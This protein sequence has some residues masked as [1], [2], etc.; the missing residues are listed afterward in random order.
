M[1]TEINNGD[2]GLAVRQSINN[3]F[4]ELY[5]MIPSAKANTLFVDSNGDD[6]TAEVGSLS[7]PWATV[8]GA[9]TYLADNNLQGYTII[10]FPGYYTESPW[11]FMSDNTTTVAPYNNNNNTTIKLLGDVHILSTGNLI[12]LNNANG[13]A[14]N[15]SIIGEN[16]KNTSIQSDTGTN[17]N[18]I[19]H[20]TSPSNSV[21]INLNIS[22]IKFI[23][24]YDSYDGNMGDGLNYYNISY[25]GYVTGKF[26]ANN[27]S[28]RN[29]IRNNWNKVYGASLAIWDATINM[30]NTYWQAGSD[31][32][33]SNWYFGLEDNFSTTVNINIENSKFVINGQ[34]TISQEQFIKTSTSISSLRYMITLNNVIFYSKHGSLYCLYNTVTSGANAVSLFILG[35]VICNYRGVSGATIISAVSVIIDTNLIDISSF[36]D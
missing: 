31:C 34:Y 20:A 22:N 5:G 26:S 33:Y 35:P 1:R 12:E 14:L 9:L 8:S 15:V 6:A 18:F 23:C 11:V 3:M 10:V 28:F 19:S 2:S 27:C 29:Y 4:T 21:D 24:H 16:I 7:S 36:Q 32:R 17:I 13:D 25:V 30:N